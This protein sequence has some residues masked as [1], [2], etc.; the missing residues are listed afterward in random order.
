MHVY[1]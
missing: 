1:W